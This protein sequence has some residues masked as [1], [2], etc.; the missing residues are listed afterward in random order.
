MLSKSSFNALLKTLE[1]P[2]A[3][4]LFIL[5]TT[6]PQKV[7]ETILSRVQRLDFGKLSRAEITKELER[8]AGLEK[9]TVE[10]GALELITTSASGSLRDA[11]SSFAKVIAFSGDTIT[12]AQASAILG[13]IPEDVHA[14]LL[15]S[16][17]ARK[18]ADAL[19][20]I[21]SLFESGVNLDHF[22]KQFIEYVRSELI[23]SL[24]LPATRDTLHD[25]QFLVGV[26]EKFMDARTSARHTPIP[27]LPLELAII[28]LTQSSAS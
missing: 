5:A 6:E 10:K 7:P 4:T 8:I 27:Q 23:S 24:T 12:T 2:P 13:I 11:L 17:H 28:E 20:Q 26:I 18:S 16:I 1:E 22:T 21:A 15:A 9:I 25:P 14:R 19:A 3:H